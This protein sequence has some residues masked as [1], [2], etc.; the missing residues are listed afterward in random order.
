[1]PRIPFS[2]KVVAVAGSHLRMR[3]VPVKPAEIQAEAMDLSARDLLVR[4]RTQ[5][6]NAI[7]QR[8]AGGKDGEAVPAW[9]CGRVRRHCGERYR[10]GR[11]AVEEDR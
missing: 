1:M 11:S 5:L 10:A 9:S 4:Q 7:A 6:V 2:P 8:S 3:F